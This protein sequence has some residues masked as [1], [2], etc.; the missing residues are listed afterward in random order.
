MYTHTGFH[1]DFITVKRKKW[2]ATCT[3][4]QLPGKESGGEK[5]KAMPS[6][7]SRNKWQMHCGQCSH[8]ARRGI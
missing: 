8:M 7:L 6:E 2:Q 5:G 4:L 1:L 3:S